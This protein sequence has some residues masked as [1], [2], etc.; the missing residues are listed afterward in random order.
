MFGQVFQHAQHTFG[1]AFADDFH[2][3]AF[4]QQFARHIERQI[5]G[6]HHTLDEAQV[7]RHQRLCVVHDEHALDIQLHAGRLVA[8][9]H[10]HRCLAGNEQ[11]LRVLGRAFHT[12]VGGGQRCFAV[13]ADLFV[14]LVVLVLRDVFFGTR[15]Q[16]RSLVHGFPFAGRDHFA[17][18]VVFAFFP[19]F[20]RHQNRQRNMVGIL[21]DDA[22]EL[23]GIQ[24]VLRLVFQVQRDAGAALGALKI[25]HL[26]LAGAFARPAHALRCGQARAAAFHRDTVSHDKARIK[27]DTEL[28][29]QLGVVFLVA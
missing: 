15:P 21:V 24:I 29:N 18:L 27:P 3:A 1:A 8:V 11:Q 6:I 19:L 26:K 17:R 25:G 7:S 12:V 9:E 4:L 2:R 22:F 28:A 20:L 5:A 23:V 13:V 16:R 10:V 14:K